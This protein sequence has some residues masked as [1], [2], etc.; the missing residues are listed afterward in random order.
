MNYKNSQDEKSW[1]GGGIIIQPKTAKLLFIF[2]LFYFLLIR[3][4]VDVQDGTTKRD[5]WEFINRSKHRRYISS[6]L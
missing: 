5:V 1:E 2:I 6:V 4:L 3:K